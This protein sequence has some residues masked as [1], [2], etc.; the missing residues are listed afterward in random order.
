MFV[1]T[2]RDN[3]GAWPTMME[4]AVCAGGE[5]LAPSLNNAGMRPWVCAHGLCA[6]HTVCGCT[7]E[8]VESMQST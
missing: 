4:G 7:H 5:A 2:L 1:R 8:S 6:I 3:D